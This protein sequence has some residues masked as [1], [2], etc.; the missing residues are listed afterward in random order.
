MNPRVLFFTSEIPQSVNAGS[1]QLYRVL[2]GYPGEKL[3]V[4]GWPPE[5]DAKLLPCRYET[6]RLFT[7]RLA[8]TRARGSTIGINALNTVWEA[9]LGRS[10]R[11]AREFRPEVIVTVMDKL[12]YYKHAWALARRLKVPL[13]T[14]TMD[15][16]EIF[17][18]A[19]P[20]LV[21]AQK[22]LLRKIY[23]YAS[24]SLGVSQEMGEYLEREFGKK[25]EVFYFGPPEGILPRSPQESSGLKNPPRLVLGYS[26]A[27]SLGY[28]EG[29]EEIL[30]ALEKAD[31]VLNV[32][33]KD[34]H[35]VLQHPRVRN[36]G[37]HPVEKLWPLVQAECDA[38]I[39]PYSSGKK[40]EKIYRTH[41]PT[42][43]SEYCWLGMPVIV[44]GPEYATGLRW[45]QRHPDACVAISDI[46]PETTG[47][48]LRQ[49]A[50]DG[51]ER[52]RL[53]VQAVALARR[54]FDPVAIREQFAKLLEKAAASG[55]N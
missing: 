43:L 54:E 46:R 49:L 5:K 28:R 51:A 22:R 26:G 19:H 10:E 29:I 31:A 17:E 37:F 12:S 1:M 4:M 20:L 24:L 30:P 9:Q 7:H 15:D 39:L 2:Q 25:T 53:A 38:V 33:T 42:K 18:A 32:Y 8:C 23:A 34:Q 6:V 16:P 55:K 36:R 11:L 48:R 3:M 35:F 21:W 52:E 50:G 27:M 47:P 45:A 44:A 41:F 14:I 13:M 40:D